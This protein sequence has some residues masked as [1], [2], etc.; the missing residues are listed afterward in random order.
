MDMIERMAV[1]FLFEKCSIFDIFDYISTSAGTSF[2]YATLILH[3]TYVLSVGIYKNK[4]KD[5]QVY[6]NK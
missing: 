3:N 4:L 5:G 6:E 2:I 1:I